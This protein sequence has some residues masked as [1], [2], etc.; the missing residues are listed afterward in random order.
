MNSYKIWMILKT[1][2]K[3]ILN[4]MILN[5]QQKKSKTRNDSIVTT[6][7]CIDNDIIFAADFWIG[8][9]M[10]F[11]AD[12]RIGSY[13]IFFLLLICESTTTQFSLPISESTVARCADESMRFVKPDR[14][15]LW[16]NHNR[17]N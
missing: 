11:T 15:Y 1:Q 6:D 10:I 5:T 8:S 3:S 13:I 4:L 2:I 17:K 7:F 16:P 9:D 12:F 14:S